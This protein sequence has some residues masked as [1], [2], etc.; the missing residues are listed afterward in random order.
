MPAKHRAFYPGRHVGDILQYG[1][2]FQLI[3]LFIGDTSGTDLPDAVPL[4]Y[5]Y[6]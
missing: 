2:L 4:P 6:Q 3:L 1:G 5:F